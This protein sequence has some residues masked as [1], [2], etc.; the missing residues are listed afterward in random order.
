MVGVTPHRP[1]R[2]AYEQGRH[3]PSR[4]RRGRSCNRRSCSRYCGSC[5]GAK[6]NNVDHHDAVHPQHVLDAV[7]DDHH[8]KNP[9]PGSPARLDRT[10]LSAHGPKVRLRLKL[11]FQYGI[12]LEL[13]LGL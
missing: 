8:S 7:D 2:F 13:G 11:R 1:R 4:D 6:L 5:G 12:G 10:S 3:D 9:D